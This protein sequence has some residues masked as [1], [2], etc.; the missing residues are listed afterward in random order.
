MPYLDVICLNMPDDFP[1]ADYCEF[2]GQARRVIAP[3]KGEVPAWKELGG[4]SNLIAWRFRASSDAWREHR[5][6]MERGT[7]SHEQYYEQECSLFTMFVAGVSCIESTCYAM[8]AAASH[9]QVCG[10]R[11]DGAMQRMCSPSRVREWLAGFNKA[12]SL[13]S[14]LDSLAASSEWRL[15]IDLRNRMTHRSNLPRRHYASVGAPPPVVKPL[16]YAPTSSTPEIDA[17]YSDWDALHG[18]L[19]HQLRVLL[20]G[21]AEMLKAC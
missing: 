17:D 1:A 5:A 12:A 14:A 20:K 10:I 3:E 15:W 6:S 16:N 2:M 4:A 19:A 11:F 9:P 7:K 13:V 21:G 8:A 18:W